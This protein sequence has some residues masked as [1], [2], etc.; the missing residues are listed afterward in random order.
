MK[1][2]EVTTEQCENDCKEITTTVQY[3]TSNDDNLLSVVEHFTKHC[4]EYEKW[5]LLLIKLEPKQ[6]LN[7]EELQKELTKLEEACGRI[8]AQYLDY[9]KDSGF[10]W[11]TMAMTIQHLILT[12]VQM[13]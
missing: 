11:L 9:H 10:W 5:L 2:F 3:V 12:T 13:L 8:R 6:M 1:V 4:E 7:K